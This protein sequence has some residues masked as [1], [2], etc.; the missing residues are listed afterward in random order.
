MLKCF[1]L[2]IYKVEKCLIF[3]YN[4]KVRNTMKLHLSSR[5]I[6]NKKFKQ[7]PNGYDADEVDNFLDK[8]L[9]DYRNIDKEIDG[10]NANIISLKRD[11]ETLKASLRDK[12]QIISVQKSKNIALMSNHQ[13]SLDNLELLQRCSAYERKL[14]ELGVDPN[15]V[16]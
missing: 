2:S 8:I 16:K 13:S 6:L 15:K 5:D 3:S 9:E 7:A 10:L 14:Y 1:K 12:E 11:N 4:K